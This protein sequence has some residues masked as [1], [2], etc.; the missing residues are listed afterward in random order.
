MDGRASD[1]GTPVRA[2]DALYRSGRQ[3][4]ALHQFHRTKQHLS[5]ELGVI[6][7]RPLLR[8][9]EDILAHDSSLESA[10]SVLRRTESG[11]AR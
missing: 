6:P 9:Y 8:L 10:E 5:D 11:I 7:G 2:A 1:A 4:D 3:S